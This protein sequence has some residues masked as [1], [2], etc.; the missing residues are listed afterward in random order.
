MKVAKKVAAGVSSLGLVL[1]MTGVASAMSGSNTGTGPDSHNSVTNRTETRARLTN[2]NDVSASNTNHQSAHTGSAGVYHNTT[3]GGA[4]T[5]AAANANSLSASVKVDNT[6][7]VNAAAD[8]ASALPSGSQSGTNSNTGPDSS[9]VVRNMVDTH[10]SVTNNNDLHVYNS[11]SQ[12][13]SSGSA[14]VAGNTTGGSAST[15]NASNTN[16]STINF[17]VSN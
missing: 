12:T 11:N 3:G 4:S 5:G 17:T 2:N 8:A 6:G 15:G 7:A 1:S 10:V 13:A 14:T 9:N 16:S